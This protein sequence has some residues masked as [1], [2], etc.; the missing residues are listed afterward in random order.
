MKKLLGH[1]LF[2]SSHGNY[3]PLKT[4]PNLQEFDINMVTSYSTMCTCDTEVKRSKH[5][6]KEKLLNS[7]LKVSLSNRMSKHRSHDQE[8]KEITSQVNCSFFQEYKNNCEK[9]ECTCPIRIKEKDQIR[10]VEITSIERR[11]LQH[12][13]IDMLRGWRKIKE[14]QCKDDVRVQKSKHR[15][16]EEVTSMWK[17]HDHRRGSMHEK[18][19]FQRLPL[20]ESKCTLDSNMPKLLKFSIWRLME[21]KHTRGGCDREFINFYIKT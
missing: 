9:F 13:P 18:F 12:M 15:F 3:A 7:P 17:I 14:C 10:I 19:T 5:Q 4:S 21:I 2:T 11:K 20:K 8:C 1:F 6:L 16:M